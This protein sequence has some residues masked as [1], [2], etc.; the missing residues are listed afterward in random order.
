M[1]CFRSTLHC[2]NELITMLFFKSMV[3]TRQKKNKII[4][5]ITFSKSHHCNV[6]PPCERE[7][8]NWYAKLIH[9]ITQMVYN[10]LLFLNNTEV[11][12]IQ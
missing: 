2:C 12:V 9:Y 3:L 1:L 11:R 4:T 6:G 8:G 10:T 5:L 7:N